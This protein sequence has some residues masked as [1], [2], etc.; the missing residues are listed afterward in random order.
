[1]RYLARFEIKWLLKQKSLTQACSLS[2]SQQQQVYAGISADHTYEILTKKGFF[3]PGLIIVS[4]LLRR[5][6]YVV[7]LQD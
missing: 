1:M 2:Y 6:D 5:S 3:V 7:I 4:V